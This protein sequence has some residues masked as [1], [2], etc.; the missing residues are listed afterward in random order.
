MRFPFTSS[1]CLLLILTLE[2]PGEGHNWMT[3]LNGSLPLSQYSIPGTHNS[4]ARF[5]PAP[6]TAKCQNLTIT[7]QLEA[8]VRFMDIRC[9]HLNDGLVIHHGPIYQ[10]ISFHD[11][12]KST[13]AFLAANPGETIIM[14]VNSEH[15]PEENTRSFEA[16][17]D[18]YIAENPN[19]WR[20]AD[21]IPT[22][23]QARGKIVLF[24]RFKATRL[25]KGIDAS[26]WPNNTT[27]KSDNHLR[28]QDRYVVSDN[29][30]K[31]NSILA[32]LKESQKG[33]PQT[34]FVNFASGYRPG[35]LGIP[36]ITSVSKNINPRL[37]TFFK[38]NSNGRFGVV[39]M[40]FIDESKTSM[41]YTTNTTP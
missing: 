17:F 20:L 15:Q 32:L 1:L 9:H 22:L 26:K 16:T 8:G 34:L 19:K 27:F 6:G 38:K 30:A 2:A 29:D 3:S 12:L 7:Q 35:L 10:K 4:G 24:R 39:L 31:W 36:S 40:D 37:A 23:D 5:E 14:S 11:V 28:I 25:P 18:S 21:S 41:I 13:L 33:D